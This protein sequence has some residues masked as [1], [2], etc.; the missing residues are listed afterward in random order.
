M[1]V[2]CGI[3]KAFAGMAL[4]ALAMM[5]TILC[6][7]LA[8]APAMAQDAQTAQPPGVNSGVTQGPDLAHGKALAYTCMGCHGVAGYRNAYPNYSVPKL[9][10]QHPEYIIASL[11][12]YRAGQ[13]SHAT[14]AA[15]AA[16]LSDQDMADV[17]AYLAGKP[18]TDVP[19]AMPVAAPPPAVA[20]C[21]ACHGPGGVAV[22]PMYPNLAGQHGDYLAREI[23]EYK[24]GGRK[25]PVMTGLA[26]TI[27]DED[28]TALAAYYAS[29]KPALRTPARP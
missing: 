29:L 11:Q 8:M 4:N 22:V 23:A 15:Q 14:M 9:E 25:N 19:R 13:R 18:L 12:A 2:R 26:A 28:V 7:A 17:A 24:H 20:V 5:V 1:S 16:S 6:V 21:A 3:V 10:G 27:R